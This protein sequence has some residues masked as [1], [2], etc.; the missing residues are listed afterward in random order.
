MIVDL[1][2]YKEW[3]RKVLKEEFEHRLIIES[4]MGKVVDKCR[5]K[6]MHLIE[7]PHGAIEGLPLVMFDALRRAIHTPLELSSLRYS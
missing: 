2:K 7:T 6:G 4:N 1:A 3:I 5:I